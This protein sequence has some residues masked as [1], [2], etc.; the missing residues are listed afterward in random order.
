[1]RRST[2]PN[3]QARSVSATRSLSATGNTPS[4]SVPLG[5][6]QSGIKVVKSGFSG[7]KLE[8]KPVRHE[9]FPAP[10]PGTN[11]VENETAIP[12]RSAS[13]TAMPKGM[14]C[15]SVSPPRRPKPV[16]KARL[17]DRSRSPTRTREAHPR[18]V[19]IAS[20]TDSIASFEQAERRFKSPVRK[21]VLKKQPLAPAPTPASTTSAKLR[22]QATEKKLGPPAVINPTPAPVPAPRSRSLPKEEGGRIDKP[23]YKAALPLEAT[24]GRRQTQVT[25]ARKV[26]FSIE[27]EDAEQQVQHPQA[28]LVLDDDD[29]LEK[30]LEEEIRQVESRSYSPPKRAGPQHPSTS[31]MAHFLDRF[32]AEERVRIE[33]MLQTVPQPPP[34]YQN[35]HYHQHHHQH[36]HPF[37][38]PGAYSSHMHR[39]HSLQYGGVGGG[40][41]PQAFRAP[42]SPSP[43]PVVPAPS[44]QSVHVASVSPLPA[45]APL[46]PSHPLVVPATVPSPMPVPVTAPA[47]APSQG[48]TASSALPSYSTRAQEILERARKRKEE[49]SSAAPLQTQQGPPSPTALPTTLIAQNVVDRYPKVAAAVGLIDDTCSET[50]TEVSEVGEV[51]MIEEFKKR[52]DKIRAALKRNTQEAENAVNAAEEQ[53]EK[54]AQDALE[55]LNAS[56]EEKYKNIETTSRDWERETERT[57][58]HANHTS[59]NRIDYSIPV[60]PERPGKR[61]AAAMRQKALEQQ[62]DTNKPLPA[63]LDPR[64]W[65]KNATSTGPKKRDLPQ[66]DTKVTKRVTSHRIDA[67]EQNIE[68]VPVPREASEVAESPPPPPKSAC[69]PPR[70]SVSSSISPRRMS[71]RRRKPQAPQVDPEVQREKRLATLIQTIWRGFFAKKVARRLKAERNRKKDWVSALRIQKTWRGW[72]A[73][74]DVN[75]Q[76]EEKS[77]LD[78][79]VR[80]LMSSIRQSASL[81]HSDLEYIRTFVQ[82]TPGLQTK[83]AEREYASLF[84]VL[85]S[86]DPDDCKAPIK[87]DRH[88]KHIPREEVPAEVEAVRD[89]PFIQEK[90]WD[91]A[92]STVVDEVDEAVLA[93][94][95][96]TKEWD[97]GP[98]PQTLLDGYKE[99]LEV[100]VE[101][102]VGR[103]GPV[104]MLES[105]KQEGALIIDEKERAKEKKDYLVAVD[106]AVD[107]FDLTMHGM[108]I[109]GKETFDHDGVETRSVSSYT[110]ASTAGLPLDMSAAELLGNIPS[111]QSFAIEQ[112]L[113]GT[114]TF[115]HRTLPTASR[116]SSLLA[117]GLILHLSH[118]WP[119]TSR[120]SSFVPPA[121]IAEANAESL[122]EILARSNAEDI[123]M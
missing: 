35:P 91:K 86:G 112:P 5:E 105:I 87:E 15:K 18:E 40:V 122:S 117:A 30:D 47:Q 60:T 59:R 108:N 25:P 56:K 89:T 48:R 97:E 84:K 26:S 121:E 82:A 11:L 42:A 106:P 8:L 78:A 20:P 66:N 65:R 34:P 85:K 54:E 24:P 114:L 46:L 99:E 81:T 21:P 31:T 93:A 103:E 113:A 76:K 64:A 115:P 37:Y 51:S 101:P 107:D 98:D 39:S 28:V 12:R 110:A 41:S 67:P 33:E 1:M 119:D 96:L 23:K 44:P 43:M 13:F 104:E 61:A 55:K 120:L 94:C 95:E 111:L 79:A 2:T 50:E 77:E 22:R 3:R 73:R 58:Y 80:L 52:S 36:H 57:P 74:Q 32:D 69:S 71:P 16:A 17:D 27:S 6:R 102:P 123:A 53:A 38:I 7:K 4:V 62:N 118:H 29:D 70:Q 90:Y 83:S 63:H 109:S 9:K 68:E 19:A 72:V 92:I 10:S 75:K 100:I 49:R 14:Q 116:S 88:F 45:P